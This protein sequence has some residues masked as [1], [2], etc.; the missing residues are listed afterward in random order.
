MPNNAGTKRF[1]AVCGD[2][3]INEGD[4]TFRPIAR[5]R[6]LFGPGSKGLR[7]AIPDFD[8]DDWPDIY[9]ANDITPNFLFINQCNA[10]EIR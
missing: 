6:G 3:S 1:A 7:V 4:G 2:A 9:V 5:E 10:F 8:D